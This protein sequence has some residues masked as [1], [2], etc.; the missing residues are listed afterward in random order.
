MRILKKGHPK[1]AYIITC[2]NCDCE[3]FVEETEM[4]KTTVNQRIALA[5]RCPWCGKELYFDQ[6]GNCTYTT[7]Y[8]Y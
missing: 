7:V 3:F 8:H 1:I 6:G 4:H 2:E 5:Y